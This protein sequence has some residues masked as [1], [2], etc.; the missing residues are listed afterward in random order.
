[1]NILTSKCAL[2]VMETPSTSGSK[3][4]AKARLVA[5][6][7]QQIH[8]VHYSRIYAP[9]GKFSAMQ[10][11]TAL[12]AHFDLKRH[13]MDVDMEFRNWKVQYYIYI[14]VSEGAESVSPGAI[15][16]RLV[17]ALFGLKQAPRRKNRKI[18]HF[19]KSMRFCFST[20]DARSCVTQSGRKKVELIGL[21]ID[22][23]L[24]D[25]KT[26]TIIEG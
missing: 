25:G 18:D 13:G 8:G 1:M 15:G 17:K 14:K 22:D 10:S 20:A 21:Y 19:L 12:V 6:G 7:L 16:W 9:V 24:I 2:K 5:R 11:M 4:F 23:L 26:L 3:I